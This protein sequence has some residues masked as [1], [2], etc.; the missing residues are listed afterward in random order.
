M[1]GASSDESR[2]ETPVSGAGKSPETAQR[3]FTAEEIEEKIKRGENLYKSVPGHL[4]P[5]D[6]NVVYLEYQLYRFMDS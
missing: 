3:R 4:L 6:N 2:P 1:S 5:R